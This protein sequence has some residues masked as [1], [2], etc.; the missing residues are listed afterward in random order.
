MK[1]EV[2]LDHS[3]ICEYAYFYH[4]HGYNTIAKVNEEDISIQQYNK[5]IFVALIREI[6]LAVR[7]DSYVLNASNYA[8]EVIEGKH[9]PSVIAFME[10]F[11]NSEEF[12]NSIGKAVC[13]D[14]PA[15][16]YDLCLDIVSIKGREVFYLNDVAMMEG[17]NR[18]K[19]AQ[20]GVMMQ[21]LL[22]TLIRINELRLHYMHRSQLSKHMTMTLTD[23]SVI[24]RYQMYMF[25][26]TERSIRGRDGAVTQTF[27]TE[28]A[29]IHLTILREMSAEMYRDHKGIIGLPEAQWVGEIFENSERIF[30]GY[31]VIG[32]LPDAVGLRSL[33]R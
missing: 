16:V 20:L 30:R 13:S 1:Y 19:K 29:I 8:K 22:P 11:I 24:R 33:T 2:K 31:F 9:C 15:K 14:I 17:V 4:Q 18:P 12:R 25:N 6:Y 21:S 32:H 28:I 10:L 7:P 26:D 27:Q 23:L 5:R 3:N